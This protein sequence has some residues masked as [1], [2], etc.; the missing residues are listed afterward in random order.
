MDYRCEATSS[1]GFVQ[2]LV[3]CYLPHGYWFYVTGSIP[4]HKEPRRVDAKLLDKY[5]I[6]ISRQSRARRKQAGLANVHYLRHERFFI[7]LATHGRHPFYSDE[8]KNIR[9]VRRAPIHFAGYSIT[10]KHGGYL[11]KAS[12]DSPAVRDNRWRVRVQIGR[13]PYRD[14]KAYFL[15]MAPH[16]TIEQLGRA[17][18]CLPYEPYARVRQQLLDILRLINQA[19]KAARLQPISPKVLRYRR[20]IVRPFDD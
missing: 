1:V 5:G 7:L 19:R 16:R 4:D 8:A 15:D 20:Q 11:R 13:D 12:P 2:Q 9:D 10:V 3:S 18:Y 14:L 6:D 17:F